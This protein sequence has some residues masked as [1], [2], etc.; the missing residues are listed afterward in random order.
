MCVVY[1]RVAHVGGCG[2]VGGWVGGVG[3]VGSLS[4]ERHDTLDSL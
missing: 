4:S 2:C 3:A 1:L